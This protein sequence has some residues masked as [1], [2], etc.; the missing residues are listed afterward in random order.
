LLAIVDE[1]NGLWQYREGCEL[2]GIGAKSEHRSNCDEE[3]KESNL[4]VAYCGKSETQKE[5]Q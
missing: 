1:A 4:S 2:L 5:L 3:K